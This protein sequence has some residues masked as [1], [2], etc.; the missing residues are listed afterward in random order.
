M[1]PRGVR[2]AATSV[3]KACRFLFALVLVTSPAFAL[4]EVGTE[5]TNEVATEPPP[6]IAPPP[7][8]ISCS[9]SR[10]VCAYPHFVAGVD[11]GVSHFSESSPFGFDTSVGSVS[12]TGPA[13]GVRAGVEFTTWFAVEAHYFGT[14]NATDP[15]H[16]AGVSRHLFT[17]AGA[18]ELRFTAPIPYVQPYVF[19]GGGVY[20]T[21]L[22]GSS[23][24]TEM[25]GS[26]EFGMPI[27]V[28]VSVP[29]SRGISVGAELVYH[30]LFGESFAANEDIGGGDP[31]SGS[32]VLRF[33]L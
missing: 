13:W 14:T 5:V 32:A 21:T 1:N 9:W 8:A 23:A 7:P 29:L 19:V 11:L 2:L 18:L 22:T 4:D 16:S 6:Q 31:T 12:S 25:T 10:R 26:T 30:R 15:V 28:G 17:N 27:G 33:R 3:M 24:S 20:S